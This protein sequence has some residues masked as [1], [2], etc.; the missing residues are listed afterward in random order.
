MS[1]EITRKDAWF[2]WLFVAIG[3]GQML[4]IRTHPENLNAPAWVAY[5]ACLVFVFGGL[6]V[7]LQAHGRAQWG[8]VFAFLIVAS[9]ATIGLWIGLGDGPR[10]C[11]SSTSVG[12]FVRENASSGLGCRIPFGL[13]GAL[14]A[15]IAVAMVVSAVRRARR[16]AYRP[17]PSAQADQESPTGTQP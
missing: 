1:R 4:L 15:V 3:F 8:G 7:V 2:G 14:C 9:F 17:Q 10:E 6:S 16:G 11:T 13:G 5:L 12:A